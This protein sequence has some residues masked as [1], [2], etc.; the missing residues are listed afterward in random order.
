M[1][2]QTLF[3][4]M[5][6]PEVKRLQQV[7]NANPETRLAANGPGSPG[8]ETTTFGSLTRNAVMKF[9]EKYGIVFS[10]DEHTT[11]YGLLGPRTRAMLGA[12]YQSLHG[13]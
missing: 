2:T 3:W 9:Q 7:L 8:N 13:E 6:S 5:E 4:G 11:G 1:V 12:V 10:G